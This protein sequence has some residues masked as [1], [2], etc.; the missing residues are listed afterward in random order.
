MVVTVVTEVLMLVVVVCDGGSFG[1][2][3]GDVCGRGGSYDDMCGVCGGGGS[4]GSG[5]SK[6]TVVRG[7]AENS[8]SARAGVVFS[9]ESR[10]SFHL[11]RRRGFAVPV[12]QKPRDSH[13]TKEDE[14][15]TMTTCRVK[16]YLKRPLTFSVSGFFSPLDR[17][18]FLCKANRQL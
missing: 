16:D 10:D 2:S 7:A 18:Y 3:D 13:L 1:D 17:L 9:V 12:S 4:G 6:G 5:G 15:N 11:S 14:D 8:L